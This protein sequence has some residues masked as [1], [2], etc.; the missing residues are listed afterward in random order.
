MFLLGPDHLL[1]HRKIAVGKRAHRHSHKVW[2]TIGFPPEIR[3]T[4]RAEMKRHVE[5]TG[6]MAAKAFRGALHDLHTG[7]WIKGCHAKQRAGPSLAVEAVTERNLR[8]LT[9][10]AERKLPAMAVGFS[11]HATRLNARHQLRK[12]D[13]NGLPGISN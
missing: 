7:P 12:D 5:P 9:A 10:A 2:K 8:R 11:D 1:G 4:F 6:G 3:T 13:G